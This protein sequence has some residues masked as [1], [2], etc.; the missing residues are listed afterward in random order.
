[1]TENKPKPQPAPPKRPEPQ[2]TQR[3]VTQTP[4]PGFQRPQRKDLDISG[5]DY[6]TR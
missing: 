3:P 1:M 6:N 4:R 2:P 5:P